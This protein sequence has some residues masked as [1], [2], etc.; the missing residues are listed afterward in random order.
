M[1]GVAPGGASAQSRMVLIE[2]KRRA[3]DARKPTRVTLFHAILT[4]ASGRIWMVTNNADASFAAQITR[5]GTALGKS[6]SL[7][8]EATDWRQPFWPMM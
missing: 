7:D 4:Y 1:P 8:G 6:R 2:A 5:L 3:Y